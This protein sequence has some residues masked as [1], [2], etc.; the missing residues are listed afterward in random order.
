MALHTITRKRHTGLPFFG[1]AEPCPRRDAVLFVCL[2]RASLMGG[3]GYNSDEPVN[4]NSRERRTSRLTTGFATARYDDL[5]GTPHPIVYQ[6]SVLTRTRIPAAIREDPSFVASTLP[7][8]V[9]GDGLSAGR[10]DFLGTRSGSCNVR[11]LL[12]FLVLIRN[13]FLNFEMPCDDSTVSRCSS[14]RVSGG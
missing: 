4:T 9:K 7:G 3:L 6:G 5:S 8:D 12:F 13:H 2:G 11:S 10:R 1:V 14:A